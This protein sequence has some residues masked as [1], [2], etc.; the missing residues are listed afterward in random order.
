MRLKIFVSVSLVILF[1]ACSKKSTL[2]DLSTCDPD[3]SYNGQVKSIIANS[4]AKSGCHNG[5][6]DPTLLDYASVFANAA[7]IKSSVMNGSMPKNSS[8]SSTDKQALLCW[9]QNGA[10]WN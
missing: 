5:S 3:V 10:K 4:C 2:I 1:F 9:I 8:L 6:A 7:R